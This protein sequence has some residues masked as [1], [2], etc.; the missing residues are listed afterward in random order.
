MGKARFGAMRLGLAL[1][2]AVALAAAAAGSCVAGAADNVVRFGFPVDYTRV[3]TF[4]TE[5]WVQGMVDYL[6][7]MNLRGGVAGYRFDWQVVDT[8][9][10]PQR[11]I[12]AYER[13]KREGVQIFNF[14]STPVS[15]AVAPRALE[16]RLLVIM[17]F[18]GRSDA[19][20]GTTFPYLFSLGAN[21]WSQ[22]TVIT[23]YIL[24][25]EGGSL[26]GKKLALVHIDSPF[27]R[28]PIPILTA[29]SERLGFQFQSFPFPSPGTEQSATWAQVR[30]FRPDWIL[31]W[32]AGGSQSVAVREAIRNG[33]PLNRV[34]SVIWLD[35]KDM[36][37]V[38]AQQAR[39]V[40]RFE[41]AVP[42]REHPVVREILSEVYEKAGRGYGKVENVGSTYYVVGITS[43]APIVEAVRIAE[44]RFGG[45]MTVEKIRQGLESLT[46]YDAGGLMPP[47][48]LTPRD[49]EGG[50][51]G[52]IS[53]WDG[54][55]WVPRTGWYSA[56]RELVWELVYKSAEEFRRSGQ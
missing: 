29:L 56:Y 42:G 30:R 44:Q 31:L 27:G 19:A 40:L 50:G 51:A 4:V 24:D 1:A 23:R 41:A 36:N 52:R 3:Y 48:T 13:F 7:L 47:I 37:I 34:V 18:H 9:N 15:R 33:F 39:G 20:D 28:E 55:R 6:Q 8:G 43:V 53:Q 46:N 25:Q 35:E 45:P 16:D 5:E 49:H 12:E 54:S 32:S 11:G 26:Q 2:V 21:Y 10:E 22:A 14:I 17:P 38:G